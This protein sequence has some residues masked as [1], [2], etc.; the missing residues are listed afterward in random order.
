MEIYTPEIFENKVC[1]ILDQ[2]DTLSTWREILADSMVHVQVLVQAEQSQPIL[3]QLEKVLIDVEGFRIVILPVEASI[4]HEKE[5]EK[6]EPEPGEKKKKDA[7]PRISREELHAD[8]TETLN[9]SWI[10]V[11]LVFLSS[12]VAAI[13]LLR[14]N[15]AV[16]IGA[17]VIAPLLGPNVAMSLA[18]TLGDTD[19]ARKSIRI[20]ALGI[21]IAFTAAVL[22]GLFIEVDPTIAEISS[23][24][25][26]TLGDI[27]L[28]LAA[29]SA[30]ALAFTT[31]IPTAL[32]GVMVAV[33]LLPPL[34][35]LGL[36]VGSGEFTMAW[37]A[38]L[39]LLTNIICI[40]LSGVVTFLARGIRPLTWWE[41]DRAKKASLRAIVFWI[42][43][44]V[45]LA[46]VIVLSRAE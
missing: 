41:A 10:F 6:E 24:T 44:L 42:L 21:G 4:P 15:V 23:R 37:G 17:M 22:F 14:D 3:D 30:G 18:T 45:L 19:L 20:N 46:I 34:V 28:A 38:L 8:I 2:H 29:G 31:G 12:V 11:V 13:G 39:L 40:N 32:V 5:A 27:F 33:A 7:S 9:L 16:V 26:V 36:L 43:L 1:A 25:E 35:V